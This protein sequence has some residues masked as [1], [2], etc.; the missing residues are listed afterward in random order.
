MR[1]LLGTWPATQTCALTKNR[2]SDPL[3]CRLALNP[4]SHTSQGSP[5]LFRWLPA[6]KSSPSQ[7]L[8]PLS[9]YCITPDGSHSCFFSLW[10]PVLSHQQIWLFYPRI[11]H[12]FSSLVSV[13]MATL[14]ILQNIC[15][16][17]PL[18]PVHFKHQL[19][20]LTRLFKHLQWLPISL[21]IKSCFTH[22][23]S[24]MLNLLSCHF[25]HWG[26]PETLPPF[27]SVYRQGPSPGQVSSNC[28][29][30]P[31]FFE[32][33]IFMF[34]GLNLISPLQRILYWSSYVNIFCFL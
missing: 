32:S 29:A 13:F 18:G 23:L 26:V 34:L 33:S 22:G 5:L 30:I 14:A 16:Q 31:S 6:W 4:L 3:V 12:R 15:T 19:Y 2:T 8:S 27:W 11:V 10:L 9:I 28:D 1:P 17:Q 7:K 25:P 21:T 20:H 24:P